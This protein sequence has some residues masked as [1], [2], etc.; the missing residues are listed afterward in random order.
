[1]LI[2]VGHVVLGFG[3]LVIICDIYLDEKMYLVEGHRKHALYA[4]LVPMRGRHNVKIQKR[5]K[6]PTSYHI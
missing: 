3:Q 2:H 4:V 5:K 1:M 6:Y